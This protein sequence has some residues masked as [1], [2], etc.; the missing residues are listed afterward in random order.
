MRNCCP[1][2]PA[3][4]CTWAAT[5]HGNWARE[6]AGRRWRN[7]GLSAVYLEFLGRLHDLATQHGRQVLYWGDMVWNHF[8]GELARL[9]PR[10]VHVDWGYY[11]LT[12]FAEHGRRLA[13]A[14]VPF[15]FAPGTF[16]VVHF[17]RVQRS[18]IRQAIAP[19]PWPPRECGAGGLLNTDWGDAG[20]WQHLPVSFAGFRRGCG[21]G[22][23]CRG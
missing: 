6:G 3:A 14:G 18:G 5:R 22:L 2:S 21:A 19:R 10:M 20:H 7:R 16:D 17:A 9:D 1:T 11:G 4:G 8:P 13:E 15:W 12:P 23:V